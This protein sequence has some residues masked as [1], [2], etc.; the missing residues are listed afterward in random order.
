MR[1]RFQF[2]NRLG[3]NGPYAGLRIALTQTGGVTSGGAV[4]RTPK[5]MRRGVVL[6]SVAALLALL[7]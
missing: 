2:L 4:A 7:D 6:E 5:P 3:L 1:R